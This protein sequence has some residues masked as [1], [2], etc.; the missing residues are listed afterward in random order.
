MGAVAKRY[1]V[2]LFETAK[3]N[4]LLDQVE[5]EL[6]A[7]TDSLA[8]HPRFVELLN[9]PRIDQQV[10]KENFNQ[11]FAS[12]LSQTMINFMNILID[13]H[14][15]GELNS[16]SEH[17]TRLANEERGMEDA[18]VTSV[19]PLSEEARER[20]KE[21]FGELTGKEIRLHNQVDPA[22]LGGII[23]Q[24]G[25]QLFDGSVAGKLARF[26][27]RVRLSKS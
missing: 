15:E 26:N 7:V 1:A 21:Q 22:I 19:Q 3:E 24:I 11:I 20:L 8:E 25:D 18:W 13:R 5:A 27:R 14:R 6:K 23:V 2:A 12:N 17:Y 10:K 16:I 4:N 9:S